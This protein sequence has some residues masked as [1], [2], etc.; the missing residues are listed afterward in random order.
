MAGHFWGSVLGVLR[1]GD[2]IY[3]VLQLT[4]PAF[5]QVKLLAPEQQ[6]S[7]RTFAQKTIVRLYD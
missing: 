1:F 4:M 2:K 7:W 3:G 5:V 6:P